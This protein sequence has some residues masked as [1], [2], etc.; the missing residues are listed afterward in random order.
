MN[1]KLFSKADS[2]VD[3]I[4][5]C[6]RIKLSNSQTLVLNGVG[7]GISQLDFDQQLHRKNAE[8]PDIYFT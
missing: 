7:T 4:L 5:S 1:K 2:L 8:V 3:K 6:P